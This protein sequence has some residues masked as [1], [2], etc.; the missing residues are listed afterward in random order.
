MAEGDTSLGGGYDIASIVERLDT[1]AKTIQELQATIGTQDGIIKSLKLEASQS[2]QEQTSAFATLK[3]SL[4]VEI[5][6]IKAAHSNDIAAAEERLQ[7]HATRVAL[8]QTTT[9]QAADTRREARLNALEAVL[10]TLQTDLGTRL[11]KHQ[12]ETSKSIEQQKM[13]IK[14]TTEETLS[15]LGTVTAKLETVTAK[16]ES[17]DKSLQKLAQTPAPAQPRSQPLLLPQGQSHP[18]VQSAQSQPLV[19]SEPQ[20]T[21]SPKPSSTS[22]P[23]PVGSVPPHIYASSP[24]PTGSPAYL[25]S[26]PPAYVHEMSS[27]LRQL[28]HDVMVI[29]EAAGRT[30]RFAEIQ[31]GQIEQRLQ[32]LNADLQHRVRELRQSQL[33]M[34]D[35]MA[36]S[37]DRC[38]A[39]VDIAQDATEE[40]CRSLDAA[41]QLLRSELQATLKT[42]AS[43]VKQQG[44]RLD[45]IHDSYTAA[46]RRID[47]LNSL[48]LQTNQESRDMS[49]HARNMFGSLLQQHQ[50][51]TYG[52]TQQLR[53]EFN[54]HMGRTTQ[55]LT[56]LKTAVMD[57]FN[58]RLRSL[59]HK[60][61]R[62]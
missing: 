46:L 40:R 51:D 1:Q 26:P 23:G 27:H 53:Q 10:K 59:E 7:E 18:L 36:Q 12:R 37:T 33:L 38:L 62:R 54:Q 24:N 58:E 9:W 32:G 3:S 19:S 49:Q 56:K 35:T 31:A 14:A 22:P 39:Q 43:T 42:S 21:A 50:H 44:E 41:L 28:Q 48:L 15:D 61:K 45:S 55:V 6:S 57:P 34:A 20:P 5:E 11:K 29:N 8:E 25:L 2:T 47:S 30:Q 17:L 16:V 4:S 13:Q 52:Q 60:V